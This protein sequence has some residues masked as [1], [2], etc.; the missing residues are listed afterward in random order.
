LTYTGRSGK[1]TPTGCIF[2]LKTHIRRFFMKKFGVVVAIIAIAAFAGCATGGGGGGGSG[3]AP[4]IVDLST[5]TQVQVINQDNSTV[6]GP[7][8]TL[9]NPTAFTRNW[10]GMYIRFPENFVDVSQYVRL[11][12]T[13]KFFNAAGEEIRPGDGMGMI[14]F[15]YDTAGDWHGPALGP[16]PNTPV[17]EMNVMGFSGLV[18]KDRGIRH[19]MNR[20]PQGIFIQRAQNQAVAFIELTS[21]VFH[22]GNYDSGAE[23]SGEGP[24]GS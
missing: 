14:V 7:V 12:V 1:I 21:V 6:G 18:H 24:E 19:N 23:V 10:Q 20:A 11:T 16:G 22:N 4:F 15:V 9:R 3:A 2:P 5:L 8:P 13:L 17:K